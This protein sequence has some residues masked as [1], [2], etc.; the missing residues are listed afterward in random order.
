MKYL[1]RKNKNTIGLN[2]KYIF[3]LCL[4]WL[5]GVNTITWGQSTSTPRT[6]NRVEGQRVI[7]SITDRGHRIV[8]M[9]CKYNLR[10]EHSLLFTP[11]KVQGIVDFHR[12]STSRISFGENRAIII[13]K[14]RIL[15]EL[16][17]RRINL[18][19]AAGVSPEF[20]ERAMSSNP[21]EAAEEEGTIVRDSIVEFP[22]RYEVY[23]F[24]EDRKGKRK[25]KSDLVEHMLDVNKSDYSYNTIKST[26]RNGKSTR[27]DFYNRKIVYEAKGKK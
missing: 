18:T 3:L 2:N 19:S 17:G 22:T 10:V 14:K 26:Q 21:R 1:T 8:H 15:L 13:E 25:R 20:I 4:L 12:D 23:F 5:S 16:G 27:M 7:D 6:L 24:P 11:I 9:Y